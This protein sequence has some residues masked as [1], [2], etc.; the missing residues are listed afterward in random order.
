MVRHG[1]GVSREWRDSVY[2]Y[3]IGK[4]KRGFLNGPALVARDDG[5]VFSGEWKMGTL[6]KGSMRPAQEAEEAE[7]RKGVGRLNA[8]IRAMQGRLR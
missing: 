1:Y 6:K 8:S 5:P 2:V 7:A 3:A 4:W